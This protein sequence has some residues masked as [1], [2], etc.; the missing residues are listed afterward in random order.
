MNSKKFLSGIVGVLLV[1]AMVA[2][3]AGCVSME[4]RVIS[5][6]KKLQDT[7]AM[8][9]KF[10]V[11]GAMSLDMMGTKQDIPIKMSMDMTKSGSDLSLK[12]NMNASV[13]GQSQQ[14]AVEMYTKDGY[15]Y[16][17]QAGQDKY[18]K[19]Q[20][21]ASNMES[22]TMQLFGVLK[23]VDLSKAKFSYEKQTL[24]VDGKSVQAD[25]VKV[26]LPDEETAKLTKSLTSSLL[27]NAGG[28]TDASSV[29][30]LLDGLKLENFSLTLYLDGDNVVREE[31][32]MK[33]TLDMSKV[34][35]IP[36]GTIASMVMDMN[37]GIDIIKTADTLPITFPEFNDSNTVSQ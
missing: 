20:T 32:A 24:T 7:K 28:S 31:T 33:L 15:S 37:I 16:I 18:I 22:S 10:T 1:I 14:I 36:A 25:K 26:A 5:G 34:S 8:Q 23:D 21:A 35:G 27:S 30:S 6:M 19:M 9:G 2:V 4:Q 13:A 29:Q 3:L 11:D 12:G 17:K